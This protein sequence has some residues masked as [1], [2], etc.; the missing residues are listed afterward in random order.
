MGD[1]FFGEGLVFEATLPI[2]FVG[3]LPP[4]EAQ[5]ARINA[6][7]RQLLSEDAS[8]EDTRRVEVLK[9]ESMALVQ[10]LQRIE[11][12][13][14]AVLRLLAAMHL[15]G[16]GTPAPHKVRLTP[17]ALE[18]FGDNAP[19]TGSIGVLELH[20]NRNLPQALRLPCVAVGIRHEGAVRVTQ[21]QFESLSEIVK[22]LIGRFIFRQ[23]RRLIAGSKQAHS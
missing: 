14:D 4:D 19:A 23:H 22:E 11:F 17:T 18:W 6:D 1:A 2:V 12:K 5:L 21:F 8:L 3:G 15:R 13:L 7:N 20:L 16:E 9:E 10:E